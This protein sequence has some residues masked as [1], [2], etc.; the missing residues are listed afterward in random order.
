MRCNRL[1]AITLAIPLFAGAQQASKP[2]IGKVVGLPS[3]F[4]PSGNC[5]S[6]TQG[7]LTM[8][9]N[10]RAKLTDSELG[11]SIRSALQQGYVITVYPETKNGVFADMECAT[12]KKATEAPSHP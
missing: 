1:F 2:Q 4:T 5:A 12:A 7:Y 6:S 11:K 8:P 10:G 9:K 3:D